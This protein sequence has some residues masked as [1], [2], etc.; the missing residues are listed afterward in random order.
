[1]TPQRMAILRALLTLDHPTA[2]QI[3]AHVHTEF[4]MTSLVTIYRTLSTLE[5][6]GEAIAVESTDAEK[7]YDGFRPV[8]HPHLVCLRCGRVADAPAVDISAVTVD[9]ASRSG[10]WELN[11]EVHFHG[12]CSA[13]RAGLAREQG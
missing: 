2:E 8:F 9:L 12:L 6:D 7:H 10:G 13:C 11:A 5:M 3:Y 1:M 4:P